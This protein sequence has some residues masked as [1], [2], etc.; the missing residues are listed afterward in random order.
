MK[1]EIDYLIAWT[2]PSGHYDSDDTCRFAVTVG[3]PT[4][5]TQSITGN[6]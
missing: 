5:A 4:D 3:K 1:L 6:K 2:S